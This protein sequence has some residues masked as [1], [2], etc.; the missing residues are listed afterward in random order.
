MRYGAGKHKMTNKNEENQDKT[1][2][3]KPSKI[4]TRLSNTLEYDPHKAGSDLSW[5]VENHYDN[6]FGDHNKDDDCL[7]T[8]ANT[9]KQAVNKGHTTN[10]QSC[11]ENALE[12]STAKKVFLGCLMVP[13]SALVTGM[14][15][16]FAVPGAIVALTGL[17]HG[18]THGEINDIAASLFLLPISAF[19]LGLPALCTYGGI[20]MFKDAKKTSSFLEKMSQL[21]GGKK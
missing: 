8:V 2:N 9:L 6:H 17:Y 18:V 12:D 20:K 7:D 14:Y 16:A 1:K 3:E 15:A 19:L 5:I 13:S 11:L 4:Y 10:V 21:Y